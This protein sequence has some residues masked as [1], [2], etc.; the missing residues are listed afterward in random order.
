MSKKRKPNWTEIQTAYQSGEG[1]IRELAIRFGVSQS[2]LEKRSIREKWKVQKQE[3]SKKVEEKVVDALALGAIA[4]VNMT[5]QR[6][7]RARDMI[8]ASIDQF[9]TDEKNRPV[10]DMLNIR[11]MLH[12]ESMADDIARRA[13]GLPDSPQKVEHSGE[14]SYK[15]VDLLDDDLKAKASES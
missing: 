3:I 12:A 11:T 15:L 13:F 14:V 6:A 9:A 2:T 7:V 8:D 4:W 10:V 5:V 1:S